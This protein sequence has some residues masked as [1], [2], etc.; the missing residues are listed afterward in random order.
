MNNK[1]ILIIREL[2]QELD[3]SLK[4]D[5][6]PFLAAIYDSEYN[7]V[8]KAFNSVVKDNSSLS[9][10]EINAIK[11]A[12]NKLK[13]YN[14]AP[15]NLSIYVTAEPCSMCSGAI[16]WAGIKRIYYSVPSDVVEKITGFDEGYKPDWI[17]EFNKRGIEVYPEIEAGLGAE[18]LKKYKDFGGIIYKPSN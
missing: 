5:F 8:S 13:T 15:Y 18:V 4:G 7:L 2:I 17:L 11:I 9:H 1:D 3:K 10:A 12:Q 6:G 14:L 16:M